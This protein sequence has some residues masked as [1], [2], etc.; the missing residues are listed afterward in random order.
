MILDEIVAH[1]KAQVEEE[2]KLKPIQEYIF[3]YRKEQVRDFSEALNKKGI[4]IISEIKKASP[5]KGI[6]Q[7]RFDP[8]SIARLYESIGADAVSVLTENKYFQG[9]DTYIKK[10][11]EVNSKPVLRKDFIL[12]EY[13][14]YQ[15]K[16]IGADA[17]L[18][19]VSILGKN[20]KRF[21]EISR[22]I[23]LHCLV[24]VHSREELEVALKAECSIIG[25][26]NRD[27]RNFTVDLKITE[28]LLRHIPEGVT[29]V[30]ESGIK[31]PEDIRYL[32][33]LGVNAVL[34]GETFMKNIED[35]DKIKRFILKARGA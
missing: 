29:V 21:Y 9:E 4:S 17:V 11:K 23:G 18:L 28:K 13:Q 31:T 15:S 3:E 16:A 26:N 25:I 2:K 19:I 35:V 10:V 14:I 27:L 7:H 6:I 5:S 12:D 20:L 1:K 8:V 24:E 34:I 22:E 30:S 33:S 32:E